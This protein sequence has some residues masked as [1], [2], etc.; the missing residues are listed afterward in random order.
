MHFIVDRMKLCIESISPKIF[1]R[2]YN[3]RIGRRIMLYIDDKILYNMA[4]DSEQYILLL[5]EY[6]E[7]FGKNI[8]NI[9]FP[10]PSIGMLFI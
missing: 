7:T 4:R 5:A 2:I 6:V 3:N 9:V 1:K 10:M 8:F